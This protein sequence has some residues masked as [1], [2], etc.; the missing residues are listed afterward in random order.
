M[1][2]DQVERGWIEELKPT[3]NKCIPAN[4]QTGDVYDQKEYTKGYLE[5]NKEMVAE[6]RRIYNDNHKEQQREYQKIREQKTVHCPH[7]DHMINLAN[8]SKHNK[9][10]KHI[11]NSE[12]SSSEPDTIM[13]EMNKLHDDNV[14]KL[15]EIHNTFDKIDKI[16][17]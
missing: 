5:Q 6:R 1:Q 10:K 7:C 3:L 11:T 12:E 13:N 15:Q 17:H 2:K 9:T 8:R 14:L 16:I 4:F